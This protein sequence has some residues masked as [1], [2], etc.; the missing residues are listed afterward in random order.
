MSDVI[1]VMKKSLQDRTSGAQE[2]QTTVMSVAFQA[3]RQRRE[4]R[5]LSRYG[6]EYWAAIW[7]HPQTPEHSSWL[8]A[9]SAARHQI[10]RPS[11]R[12]A[13]GGGGK[14]PS[15][16]PFMLPTVM[17]PLVGRPETGPTTY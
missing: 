7:P 2:K 16:L 6:D 1:V 10:P 9:N 12:G 15:A 11:P 13:E 14:A 17:A 5:T 4:A 3:G 8:E